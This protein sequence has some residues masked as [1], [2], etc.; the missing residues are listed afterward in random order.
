MCNLVRFGSAESQGVR[1]NRREPPKLGSAV[2]VGARLTPRHRG[3]VPG[4]WCLDP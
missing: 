2:A 4:V 3:V 1:I